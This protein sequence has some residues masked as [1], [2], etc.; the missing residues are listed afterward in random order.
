MVNVNKKGKD[1]ERRIAKRIGGRRTP[2][3]GGLDIKGDIRN[4]SGPFADWVVE[5]K[6]QEKGSIWAFIEQ[7]KGE[8]SGSLKDWVVV[9]KRNNV[10]PIAVI[11]FESWCSLL[12]QIGEMKSQLA[13]YHNDHG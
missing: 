7:A 5:C 11:D 13:E 8:V 1:F 12:E 3:S 6:A 2:C 9:W 4:L 10:P